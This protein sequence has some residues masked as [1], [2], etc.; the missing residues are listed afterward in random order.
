MIWSSQVV[1][2]AHT[3]SSG[4][5][6]TE[7]G[8]SQAQHRVRCRTVRAA[9]KPCLK[10]PSPKITWSVFIHKLKGVTIWVTVS[11]L[12]TWSQKYPRNQPNPT[13][14]TWSLWFA[15]PG[16]PKGS[17][18]TL[19]S[20]SPADSYLGGGGARELLGGG[21]LLEDGFTFHDINSI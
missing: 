21:A 19:N 9:E 2:V 6:S 10:T 16:F 11:Q 15:W 7:T 13:N 5:G 12:S 18:M 4:T 14:K 1:V 20:W 3:F 17:F 8:N